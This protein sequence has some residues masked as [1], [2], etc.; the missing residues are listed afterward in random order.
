M[1][2]NYSSIRSSLL[3]TLEFLASTEKQRRFARE[4]YYR[5]YQ[6]EFACWWLDEYHPEEAVASGMFTPE[7]AEILD[8]F[9]TCLDANTEQ[10][11]DQP[12]TIEQLQAT[13]QWQ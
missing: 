10:L 12:L 3:E 9:S 11:G 13:L 5:S 6:D 8:A 7:Q 1:N 4:T 2:P